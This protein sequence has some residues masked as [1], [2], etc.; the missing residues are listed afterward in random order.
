MGVWLWPYYLFHMMWIILLGTWLQ[1]S[2]MFGIR[3]IF[4][5]FLI[6]MMMILARSLT[7]STVFIC[8]TLSSSQSTVFICFALS[9]SLSTVFVLLFPSELDN[10]LGDTLYDI[11]GKSKM[12]LVFNTMCSQGLQKQRSWW[13]SWGNVCAPPSTSHIW[14]YFP[15]CDHSWMGFSIGCLW[16]G[17]ACIC[18]CV[19]LSLCSLFKLDKIFSDTVTVISV[20]L[21]MVE[22]VLCSFICSCCGHRS[23]ERFKLSVVI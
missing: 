11:K 13:F 14:R 16:G 10:M 22:V 21:W 3:L 1:L 17:G 8:F 15:C 5:A 9:S 23:N 12:R 2:S 4:W 18:V 6:V 7:L 20:K 19:S